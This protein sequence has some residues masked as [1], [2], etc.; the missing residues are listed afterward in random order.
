[1][2]HVRVSMCTCMC[3]RVCLACVLTVIL[4]ACVRF[5]I[6]FSFASLVGFSELCVL[7]VML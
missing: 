4:C 7:V 2:G 5:S 6:G 1:M 3:A